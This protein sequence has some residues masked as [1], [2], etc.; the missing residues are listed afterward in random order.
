M[1]IE[2]RLQAL[3]AACKDGKVAKDLRTA[4]QMLLDSQG[5]GAKF[6]FLALFPAV[7]ERILQ[8]YPPYGFS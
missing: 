4:H 3:L 6:R 7:M 1:G 2:M 5:M 8:R